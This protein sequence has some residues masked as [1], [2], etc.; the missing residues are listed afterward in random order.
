VGNTASIDPTYC[1]GKE[2]FKKSYEGV[3]HLEKRAK[4]VGATGVIRTL[5]APANK[6]GVD[7]CGA[8]ARRNWRPPPKTRCHFLFGIPPSGGGS[9]WLRP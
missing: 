7:N 5:F 9:A 8:T 2:I 4:N 3:I 1:G 6:G